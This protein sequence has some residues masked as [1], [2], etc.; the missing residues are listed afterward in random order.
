MNWWQKLNRYTAGVIL[1]RYHF[2]EKDFGIF[3]SHKLNISWQQ[4]MAAKSCFWSVISV[5]FHVYFID[6]IS[7]CCLMYVLFWK[8]AIG[9]MQ[10]MYLG[11]MTC[12]SIV[13]RLM[14]VV[15][16]QIYRVTGH[17]IHMQMSSW[18]SR[19]LY[20]WTTLRLA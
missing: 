2:C 1:L 3:I 20:S 10:V 5:V 17:K 12:I 7:P 4:D 8:A 6:I 15:L 11:I 13:L 14:S 9:N 16:L 19:N 18:L